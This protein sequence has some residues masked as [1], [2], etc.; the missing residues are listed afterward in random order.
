MSRAMSKLKND[1]Y[2]Y[3]KYCPLCLA[4]S[5]M[6]LEFPSTVFGKIHLICSEC[7]AKWHISYGRTVFDLRFK[8]AK[9]VT[10]SISAKGNELL[11]KKHKPEFW[12][13]MAL[14]GRKSIEPKKVASQKTI[15]EKEIIKEVIVKI[16]CPNCHKLY[17]ETH[18]TC[19]HCG[20]SR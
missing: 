6:R 20:A 19:P 12:Q 11:Q 4:E 17:D 1:I 10:A 14:E 13:H 5:S 15:K 8:W 2:T 9:L 7:G 16:R 18:D 3:F